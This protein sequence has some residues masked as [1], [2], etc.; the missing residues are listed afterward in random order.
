[1]NVYGNAAE[2]SLITGIKHNGMQGIARQ[3][4]YLSNTAVPK[5]K[6]KGMAYYIP[7][8]YNKYPV[9]NC[10]SKGVTRLDYLENYCR[11]LRKKR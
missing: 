10:T 5:L 9:Y 2:L 7:F 3:Y 1:M 11:E 8:I 4:I 6:E